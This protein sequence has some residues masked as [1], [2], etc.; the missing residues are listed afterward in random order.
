MSTD[1]YTIVQNCM[2]RETPNVYL[3]T[4]AHVDFDL[5]EQFFPAKISREKFIE[6]QKLLFKWLFVLVGSIMFHLSP[7]DTHP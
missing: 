5:L 1:F 2:S 6:N 3:N 7:H 4:F